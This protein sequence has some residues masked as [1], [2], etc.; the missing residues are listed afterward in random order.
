MNDER[1]RCQNCIHFRKP[2]RLSAVVRDQVSPTAEEVIKAIDEISATDESHAASERHILTAI[3]QTSEEWP[4]RPR[5]A[6]YCGLHEMR[7][8]YPVCSVKNR[9]GGC[10]DY[11]PD[12][13]KGTADC[14]CC[15]QRVNSQGETSDRQMLYKIAERIANAPHPFP[16]L[17]AEYQRLEKSFAAWKAYEVREAYRTRGILSRAPKYLDYCKAWSAVDSFRLPRCINFQGSCRKFISS[18]EKTRG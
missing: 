12:P 15:L 13:N 8:I 3:R 2:V 10:T 9:N 11:R 16:P 6:P 7:E 14:S 18:Q 1:P 17:Q 5:T 4:Q